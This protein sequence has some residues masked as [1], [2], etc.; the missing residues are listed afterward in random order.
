MTWQ[1]LTEQETADKLR[2]SVDSLQRLRAEG[3]L[4]KGVHWQN[5]PRGGVRYHEGA[6]LEWY[7]TLHDEVASQRAL[8][9][10]QQQLLSNKRKKRA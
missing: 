7:A 5:I 4:I 10:W 9:A 8:E 1:L 3:T 6:I 2:L